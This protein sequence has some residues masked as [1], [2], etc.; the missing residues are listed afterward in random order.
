[1]EDIEMGGPKWQTVE[2][3]VGDGVEVGGWEGEGQGQE[4]VRHFRWSVA[5]NS[6]K[7]FKAFLKI[8]N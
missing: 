1:M 6:W 2:A 4:P 7:S 3:G 8:K 5:T